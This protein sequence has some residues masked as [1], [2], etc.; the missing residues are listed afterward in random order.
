[1]GRRRLLILGLVLLATPALPVVHGQADGQKPAEAAA[2][3]PD[4][5]PPPSSLPDDL[6]PADGPAAPGDA[7]KSKPSPALKSTP[8]KAAAPRAQGKASAPRSQP[9]PTAATPVQPQPRAEGRPSPGPS[10]GLPDAGGLPAFTPAE[11]VLGPGA[12]PRAAGGDNPLGDPAL[13]RTEGRDSP[14]DKKG[15][16][17]APSPGQVGEP[18]PRGGAAGAGVGRAPAGLPAENPPATPQDGTA[19]TTTPPP[20]GGPAQDSGMPELSADRLPL[21]KQAVAVTVDV[22]APASM[23][24]NQP[25]TLRLIVRNAGANEA[26][27]VRILDNLPDGLEYRS[28][29]PE[30]Y[31]QPGDSL[32]SWRMN[33]LPA[34]SERVLTVKVLP[35][36]TGA[37]VHGATVWFQTGSKSHTRVLR[38][39]LKVDQ[40]VSASK[41]LK[42][43][44][45][46]FKVVVTN[47]GD[48]PARDVT[49]QAKLTPGLR[50]GSADGGDDQM[51]FELTLPEL[52]PGQHEELDPLVADA[53]QGGEQSCTVT[54]TSPDVI[55]F[56]KDEAEN[57]QTALVVEPK[58]RLT[59][60]GPDRR[61]TDTVAPYEISVQNPGTAPAR[62]VRIL[63][64]LP[65][66]GRLIAVPRNA[67][68]DSAT[69]R[70]QWAPDQVEAGG[71]AKLGFAVRMGGV[72]HYQV[73]AEA[74]G[75]GGLQSRDQFSTDVVGMPDVDLVVSERQRVVDVGGKTTFQIRLRN[76]GTKDATNIQM[77]AKLSKNLAV[78]GKA[79][80]AGAGIE[81]WSKDDEVKIGDEQGHGIARLGPGKEIL[82]GIEVKVTGPE[83][84]LATCRVSVTHDDLSEPF[85]DMAG[86]KVMTSRRPPGGSP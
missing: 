40:T 41:V 18:A 23:N 59:L 83:P 54:A 29:Q 65:V 75:E 42:G 82:M 61:Y 35:K 8:T 80:P 4:L 30:A 47:I 10:P 44:A 67:D 43:Q 78:E 72:G 51:L 73:T 45:V 85:E 76:Y 14:Q 17:L 66:S 63:A 21:G 70:L 11:D 52:A 60:T 55:P 84:M 36:K 49:I 3:G 57:T 28:S 33:T 7:P 32:L 5:P 68:Y 15:V 77:T 79:V 9:Q 53:I 12:L 19:T 39:R 31:H 81:M 25:A 26:T 16:G 1:M 38:P 2:P 24:L 50:H 48:G 6:P 71:Q 13:S 56:V 62:Q 46:E 74:R 69:R 37:F 22:Q 58:L 34:G 27:N 20:A 86:V 64:T